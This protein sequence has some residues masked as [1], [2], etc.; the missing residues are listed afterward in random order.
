VIHGLSRR[1]M[2]R[3]EDGGRAASPAVARAPASGGALLRHAIELARSPGC[4]VVQL[5]T[6]RSPR[7]RAPVLRAPRFRRE[8]CR[9]KLVRDGLPRSA[10]RRFPVDQM[11]VS[12]P[13]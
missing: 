4:G 11:F 13:E 6:D 10:R 2:T 8:P 5:T 9:M 12:L 1:G 7:G 3:A